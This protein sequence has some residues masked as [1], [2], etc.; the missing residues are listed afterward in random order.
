M[1]LAVAAALALCA[2]LGLSA[3]QTTQE[4][5]AER[6]KHAKKLGAEKKIEIGR[7]NPDVEVR[8]TALLQDANGIAAVIALEN[9]G[10][11]DQ[12]RLPLAITVTDAMGKPVYR[13]N[14]GGLDDTL[15]VLP[16]LEKGQVAFWVNNQVT[17]AGK[18]VK[19]V[20]KVGLSKGSAPASVPRLRIAD[21]ELGSDTDGVFAKGTILNESKIEQ[22]RLVVFCVARKG[23][24]VVAAGR[25]VIDRL[26]PGAAE[27][28]PFTVF[29]IGNPKGAKLSFS[30]P[31]TVLR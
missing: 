9:T 23:D 24:E 21:V 19:V 25:A 30:A 18:A 16:V 31:P 17:A 27:P 14:V 8:G 28:T 15:T 22:K 11:T 3:C 1:R 10:Q 29:F 12:I 6:A 4:L 5:S 26:A 2:C 20:A 7:L 13:N